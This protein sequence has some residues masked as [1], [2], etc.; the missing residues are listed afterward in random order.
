[1]CIGVKLRVGVLPARRNCQAC[2]VFCS[3]GFLAS[4]GLF[5][6]VR[7]VLKLCNMGAT[8][9]CAHS[10]SGASAAASGLSSR[11]AKDVFICPIDLKQSRVPGACRYGKIIVPSKFKKDRSSSPRISFGMSR[12]GD[13]CGS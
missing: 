11:N 6:C 10:S 13:R 7:E 1:M 8:S 3:Q 5:A 12:V 9:S 4:D 2:M